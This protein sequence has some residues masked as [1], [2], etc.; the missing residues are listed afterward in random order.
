MA[1]KITVYDA[2]LIKIVA[3]KTAICF[4]S[5]INKLQTCNFATDKTNSCL[6]VPKHHLL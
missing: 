2:N 1:K 3:G 6:C 4:E 5:V